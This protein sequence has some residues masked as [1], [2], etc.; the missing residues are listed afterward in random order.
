M[1]CKKVLWC[2][3]VAL[4]GV[5]PASIA[6]EEKPFVWENPGHNKFAES[7]EEAI[8]RREEAFRRLGFSEAQIE[9][10]I[11]QTDK[12]GVFVQIHS[13]STLNGMVGGGGEVYSNFLVDFVR[14]KP[15]LP[16]SA[17]AEMWQVEWEGQVYTLYLPVICNNWAFDVQPMQCSALQISTLPG[18]SLKYVV[19]T[20]G[21]YLPASGCQKVCDDDDCFAP[22]APCSDCDWVGTLSATPEDYSFVAHSGEYTVKGTVQTIWGPPEMMLEYFGACVTRDGIEQNGVVVRPEDWKHNRAVIPKGFAWE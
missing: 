14:A 21:N 6:A 19:L 15:E 20:K 8:A 13:G 2:L 4:V 1:M 17:D 3:C 5:T 18:D 16:V 22:P 7:R 10:F 11:L 9:A 12:P